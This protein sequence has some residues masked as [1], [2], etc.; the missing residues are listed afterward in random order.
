MTFPEFMEFFELS[1]NAMKTQVSERI[2]TFILIH[3]SVTH[4]LATGCKNN[5]ILDNIIQ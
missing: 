3:T 2:C 4:V 5:I 1:D